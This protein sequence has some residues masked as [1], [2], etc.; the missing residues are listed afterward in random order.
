MTQAS[1]RDTL[2]L[3]C[4]HRVPVCTGTT[5]T[6]FN[7]CARGA[8]THGDVLNLYTGFFS[9]P[10][11]T[12]RTH[13]DHND[14]HTRHNNHQHK[15]TRRQGQTGTEREAEKE[16]REKTEEEDRKR[17]EKTEEERQGKTKE[18][19]SQNRAKLRG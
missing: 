16:D 1:T 10:H 18:K 19:P 2:M 3:L 6:C 5:G 12:A 7:T 15:D 11:H 14:I 4:L 8:S 17:A 13:H 9:V